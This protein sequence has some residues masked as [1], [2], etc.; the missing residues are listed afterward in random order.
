MSDDPLLKL[1]SETGLRQEGSHVPPAPIY[2]L[3]LRIGPVILKSIFR[4]STR[5]YREITK[6]GASN[7]HR[8]PCLTC[9]PDSDDCRCSQNCAF[10]VKGGTLQ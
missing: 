10:S 9:R 4:I 8:K 2:S 6:T 7:H 5:G 1:A 3:L